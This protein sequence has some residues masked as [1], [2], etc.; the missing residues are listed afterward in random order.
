MDALRPGLALASPDTDLVRPLLAIGFVLGLLFVFL[1]LVRRL[2]AS[3][4]L[5]QLARQWRTRPFLLLRERGSRP[6][7]TREVSILGQLALTPTHRL[8]VV[9]LRGRDVVVV[10]HPQ[11]CEWFSLETPGAAT[12][13]GVM[14][15]ARG[16]RGR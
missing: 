16:Q 5:A 14:D 12:F 4:S 2:A 8:H 13:S 15:E 11:G 3:G 1:F 10:T 7:E 6:R 9:S